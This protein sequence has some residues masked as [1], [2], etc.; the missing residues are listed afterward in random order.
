MSGLSEKENEKGRHG[1]TH[2]NAR[3]L[4]SRKQP[5]RRLLLPS[6][7]PL[8]SLDFIRLELVVGNPGE[9]EDVAGVV[10]RRVDEVEEGEG[11]S[12]PDADGTVAYSI[13]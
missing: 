12:V 11:G 6:M 1:K 2:L 3:I 8:R 4:T 13:M 5:S 10:V 9:G 7:S